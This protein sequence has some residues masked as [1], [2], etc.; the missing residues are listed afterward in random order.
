[1]DVDA[2]LN[3]NYAFVDE[4]GGRGRLRVRLQP[5]KGALRQFFKLRTIRLGLLRHHAS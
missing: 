1:M 5:Q 2:G 3:F 4:A